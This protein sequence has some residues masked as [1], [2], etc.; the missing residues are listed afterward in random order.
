MPV[1]LAI[2]LFRHLAGGTYR[3]MSEIVRTC[4]IYLGIAVLVAAGKDH[5][6]HGHREAAAAAFRQALEIDPGN[7]DTQSLLANAPGSP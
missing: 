4:A 3:N 6:Q 5:L 7:T 2:T 1:S